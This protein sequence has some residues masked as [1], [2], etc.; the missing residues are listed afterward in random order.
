M[1]DTT[2]LY[3]WVDIETTGLDHTDDHLL[4]IGAIS[5]GTDLAIIGTFHAITGPPAGWIRN[6]PDTWPLDDV[7]RDM[8]ETSG[9]LADV[10]AQPL[11]TPDEDDIVDAFLRWTARERRGA[12][13]DTMTLAGSGVGGFDKPWLETRS[14][15]YSDW[16]FDYRILDISPVRQLLHL[17]GID[18]RL[19]ASSGPGKH[20]R[21]LDDARAHLA[22]AR[23][24]IDTLSRMAQADT[25]VGAMIDM[26]DGPH[27]NPPGGEN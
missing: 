17:A 5:T 24:L 27:A 8:H 13:A 15:P 9:L 4:E 21:A 12:G 23:L 10:A 3:I 22:E 14:D 19:D 1:T 25:Y 20:H 2:T 16:P 18:V 7:V 6:M 11:G 26:Q